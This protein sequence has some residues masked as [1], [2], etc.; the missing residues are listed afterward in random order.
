MALTQDEEKEIVDTGR[1]YG[2]GG[3]VFGPVRKNH[4]VA[5]TRLHTV[6]RSQKGGTRARQ[7]GFN[8]SINPEEDL[9]SPN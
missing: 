2:G 1:R 4:R 8:G 5:N 9:N 7:E 6:L 3:K